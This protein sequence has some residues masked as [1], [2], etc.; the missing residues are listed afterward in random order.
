MKANNAIKLSN[1]VIGV[2]VKNV[3]DI[4]KA[5]SAGLIITDESG[6]KYISIQKSYKCVDIQFFPKKNAV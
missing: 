4:V 3:Q 1:N 5:Q 2:E 6:P